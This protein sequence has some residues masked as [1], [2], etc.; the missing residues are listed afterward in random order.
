ML[1]M[2]DLEQKLLDKIMD[3]EKEIRQKDDDIE[4]LK[5]QAEI[6][7]SL[8]NDFCFICNDNENHLSCCFQMKWEDNQKR[9]KIYSCLR[10]WDMIQG[11]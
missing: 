9:R 8:N 11:F 1:I 5:K 10:C 4:Q 6:L 2:N 7:S 3:L